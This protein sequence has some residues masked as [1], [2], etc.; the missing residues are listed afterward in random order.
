MKVKKLKE[1]GFYFNNFTKLV[2]LLK[3]VMGF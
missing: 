1:S 3:S 2:L